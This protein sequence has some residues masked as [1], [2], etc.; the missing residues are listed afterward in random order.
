VTIEQE[1]AQMFECCFH[2]Q[3]KAGESRPRRE[4]CLRSRAAFTMIEL[5]VVLGMLGILM[6]VTFGGIGQARRRAKI[7]KTNAEVRELV[8]AILSYEAAEGELAALAVDPKDATKQN[9]GFLLGDAGGEGSGNNPVV[10][11]NAPMTGTPPAFR[12]PWGT[13]YRYRIIEGEIQAGDLTERFSATVTF[14]N[15][16]RG[17]K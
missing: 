17:V 10:Y 7:T 6:G 9:I 12:D 14:P 15:R 2:K 8:N 5:L 11:L 1:G 13:P 3:D 16:L 4:T